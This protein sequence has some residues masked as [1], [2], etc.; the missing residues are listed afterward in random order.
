ML[1][2]KDFNKSVVRWNE[3]C[4]NTSSQQ[5]VITS[6]DYENKKITRR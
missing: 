6:T 1:L 3:I 2:W 5:T 4:L